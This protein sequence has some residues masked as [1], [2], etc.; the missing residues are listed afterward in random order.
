M[1]GNALKK[2]QKSRVSSLISTTTKTVTM[3]V[4]P[5]NFHNMTPPKDAN[6]LKVTPHKLPI[7]EK[8]PPTKTATPLTGNKRPAPNFC[9]EHQIGNP[10]RRAMQLIVRK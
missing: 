7:S 5:R 4:K 6:Y 3:A 1:A 10:I 8:W 2:F 9:L